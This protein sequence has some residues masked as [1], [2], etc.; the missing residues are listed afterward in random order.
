MYH[1]SAMIFVM[2][3]AVSEGTTTTNPG[4]DYFM[5]KNEYTLDCPSGYRPM[6][7]NECQ[8]TAYND[9]I[10]LGGHT[11]TWNSW[12]AKCQNVPQPGHPTPPGYWQWPGTGCFAG[13]TGTLEFSQC[14]RRPLSQERYRGIC[15]RIGARVLSPRVLSPPPM[16]K[17]YELTSQD[18]INLDLSKKQ[19]KG[20]LIKFIQKDENLR[21]FFRLRT[22]CQFDCL[23]V[24]Q[25]KTWTNIFS[26][27]KAG[28]TGTNPRSDMVEA[29]TGAF[30][31][32]YPSQPRPTTKKFIDTVVN[33]PCPRA[34]CDVKDDVDRGAGCQTRSINGQSKANF[35]NALSQ[36]FNVWK[37]QYG[38]NTVISY[39]EG[40]TT[41]Q[42][43][44]L[45]SQIA[46][47]GPLGTMW[48]SGIWVQGGYSSVYMKGSMTGAF[49]ACYPKSPMDVAEMFAKFVTDELIWNAYVNT[50]GERARLDEEIKPEGQLAAAG[51]T[52]SGLAIPMAGGIALIATAMVGFRL[53]KRRAATSEL[54]ATEDDNEA[55]HE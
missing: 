35:F 43:D 29:F 48:D 40:Q 3:L 52:A 15:K 2:L 17:C 19:W 41:C 1:S 46:S 8:A 5:V 38:T 14:G 10:H 20:T 51:R 6:T 36:S 30:R 45:M 55:S 11:Y 27:L 28:S 13:E 39:M 25:E 23:G 12:G 42:R 44:C 34:G 49:R 32:C 16:K 33:N 21:N 47:D 22:Q 9:G 7:Y 18:Q 26:I 37:K 31:A 54:L 4:A 24:Q 53:W 50:D